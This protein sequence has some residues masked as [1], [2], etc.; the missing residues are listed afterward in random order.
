MEG[1]AEDAAADEYILK[2]QFTKDTQ[3]AASLE[4]GHFI[5]NKSAQSL[6]TLKQCPGQDGEEN[7]E[8]YAAALAS[9]CEAA[10]G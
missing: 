6:S 8:E 9:G 3:K 2:K 7:V 1:T 5:P 4:Q 10:A